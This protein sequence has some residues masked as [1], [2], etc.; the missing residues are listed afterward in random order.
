MIKLEV[1]EHY[2]PNEVS[3]NLRYW[4]ET[5]K[6]WGI[7]AHKRSGQWYVDVKSIIALRE[8]ERNGKA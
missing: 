3:K 8:K 6:K 1:A 5:A 4:C 7:K 2:F